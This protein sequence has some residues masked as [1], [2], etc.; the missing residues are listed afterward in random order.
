[1]INSIPLVRKISCAENLV[2]FHMWEPDIVETVCKVAV[3]SVNISSLQPW[4][5]GR[6]NMRP[7]DL[8]RRRRRMSYEECTLV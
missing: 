2:N 8:E 6:W 4:M 7:Q 5:S 1:M 3:M